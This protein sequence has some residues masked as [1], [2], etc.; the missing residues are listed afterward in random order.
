M[1]LLWYTQGNVSNHH[2]YE[3]EKSWLDHIYDLNKEEI[4]S[5]NLD[6]NTRSNSSNLNIK[7]YTQQ[8]IELL[9]SP[10]KIEIELNCT[11]PTRFHDPSKSIVVGVNTAENIAALNR[12]FAEY[13]SSYVCILAKSGSYR[14]GNDNYNYNQFQSLYSR[15]SINDECILRWYMTQEKYSMVDNIL[16]RIKEIDKLVSNQDNINNNMYNDFL[17]HKGKLELTGLKTR[18]HSCL[19]KQYVNIQAGESESFEIGINQ[20]IGEENGNGRNGGNHD[21]KQDKQHLFVASLTVTLILVFDNHTILQLDNDNGKQ[22]GKITGYLL[23]PLPLL[24]YCNDALRNELP[25]GR[26]TIKVK[27]DD[28]ND[29]NQTVELRFEWLVNQYYALKYNMKTFGFQI[30][31][32][33]DASSTTAIN[34]QEIEWNAVC[35]QSA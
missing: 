7:E 34:F 32:D 13:L 11:N 8:C 24:E 14:I 31:I 26:K 20:V 4:S 21:T 10:L 18:H 27:R 9:W 25:L 2:C 1:L 28:V 23:K 22:V 6:I 5:T 12:L 15:N 33:C 19:T 35:Q 3:C 16:K 17:K 30:V 29:E